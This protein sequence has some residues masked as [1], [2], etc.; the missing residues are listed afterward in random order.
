MFRQ[1][2]L[3]AELEAVILLSRPTLTDSDSQKVRNLLLQPDWNWSLFEKI[4]KY[5]G[6][7]NL[8]FASLHG[9][10]L[11]AV[12]AGQLQGLQE[13][14]SRSALRSTALLTELMT[15]QS[16]FAKADVKVAFFKGPLLSQFVYGDP[17]SREFG[18]LDM[19]AFPED[20]PS[21]WEV[22]SNNGFEIAKSVPLP[23]MELLM[24]LSYEVHFENCRG[25]IVDLHW[26]VQ[27]QLAETTEAVVRSHLQTVDLWGRKICTFD[28]ELHFITVCLH[29]AKGCWRRLM[30]ISD[31]AHFAAS[32][33]LDWKKVDAL[34]NQ[35]GE[36]QT[37]CL[38]LLLAKQ[39]M[40]VSVPAEFCQIDGRTEGLVEQVVSL[41]SILSEL[42]G[43]TR[44][45]VWKLNSRTR[46]GAC[47]KITLFLH[48]LV[49]PG[50]DDW[51]RFPLPA[52]C[53]WMYYP[54][55]FCHELAVAGR[56]LVRIA[57]GAASS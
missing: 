9:K 48:G 42:E 13:H 2:P 22:L 56:K 31:I 50:L 16:L 47:S 52:Q 45:K 55:H 6:V 20:M 29:A 12:P 39:L 10:F 57:L 15:L 25:V 17:F 4:I 37:V 26:K 34:S 49:K 11:D 46:V 7:A 36:K 28:A 24:R 14:I 40:N 1:F 32:N 3:S 51:Q 27:P 18:D 35:L 54:L 23:S 8:V 5:H 30:W 33:E 19:F 38:A 21:V 41:L 43:Q 44:L 53:F